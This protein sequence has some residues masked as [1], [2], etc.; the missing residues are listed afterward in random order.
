LTRAIA[1]NIFVVT[2]AKEKFMPTYEYQCTAC[3]HKFAL[4]QSM[5][6]HAKGNVA[7]PKCK[8]KKSRQL[9]STFQTVT[10]R[11]S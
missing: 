5:A 2:F 8:K 11:K 6:E 3:K 4:V 9:I 7:C 1:V 10:S